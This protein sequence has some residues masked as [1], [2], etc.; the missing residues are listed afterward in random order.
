MYRILYNDS[1]IFDPYGNDNEVVT[2]ASMSVEINA[3]AYMDFAMSRRHPL[4][5]TIAERDGV[6]T[7]YWD[8]D[9]LFQGVIESIDMDINGN[10]AV[11]CVSALDYLNDTVVRP[12]ST[13][14]GEQELTAPSSVDGYFQWLI[15]Q[16]NKHVKDSNKLFYIGVNQGANLQ[17]NN[18]IYRSSTNNP[19]TASEISNQIIDSLGGYLLM[20]YEDGR[21]ILDLYS[22][23]H[24]MNAQIIDFGVNLKDFSKKI[25]TNDQYTALI[26]KGGSPQF[27][28]GGFESGDFSY[29]ESHPDTAIVTDKAQEGSYS[30]Y[31][32]EGVAKYVPASFF[33]AKKNGRYKSTVYVKN[34]RPSN[35][36]IHAGYQ[37]NVLDS[38]SNDSKTVPFTIPNDDQWHECSYEFSTGVENN[39]KIRPYWYSDNMSNSGN[40]RVY[41]DGFGFSRLIGNNTVSE[42]PIDLTLIPNDGTRYDSDIIKSEDV[43]YNPNRVLR[44]GYREKVFTDSTI[45]NVEDLMQAAI[46]ELNKLAEPTIGLDV[47][48]IDLALYMDGYT[49]LN[50]GDAV[51]VRSSIHN[52]D[53]Y[54]MVSSINLNLQDP[55]NSEYVIGQAYDSL[56]G[57]QSGYLRSLSSG[58]NSSLDAVASLDQT[59]KDQAIKIGSVTEA[60]KKAQDTAD[61][62]SSKAD[63]AQQSADNAQQT[64]NANK[65]QISAVKDKQSKQDALIE[66]AKKDIAAS[67]SEISGI[68]DRMT[69]MDSDIDKVQSDIDSTRQEAQKN[70]E[71]FRAETNET[72]QNVR[73]S[74]SKAQSDVDAVAKKA[75]DLSD[76]LDATKATVS[77]TVTEFGEVKTTATNA[78]SK[79]D[80]SLQ[81][82]TQASQTATSASQKATSAYNDAQTAITKSSEAVQTAN[83]VSLSL[84]TDY[85]TKADADA[86]YATQSS[87]TATSD[88]IKTEVSKT[89]ATKATVD[90]LE[91]IANNAIQTWTGKG[92]P[93]LN[94]KPAS[95]WNT[96][97][98][99]TQHSGDI[100][101][102]TDTGYS[103]RFGSSDGSTYSWTLIKD[104]DISKA[105]ADA[106]KAQKT[107]DSATSGVSE[108]KSSIPVTYATKTELTQKADSITSRV[109][110][111][112][113]AGTTTS[114]KV[115]QLEQKTD[116]IKSTVSEQGSKL[117]NAVTTISQ[118]SQKADSISTSLSQTNKNLDALS[119]NMIKNPGFETGDFTNWSYTDSSKVNQLY[120]DSGNQLAGIYKAV[121]WFPS[122]ADFSLSANSITV[123]ANHTYEISCW[124]WNDK[125]VTIRLGFLS[126][127]WDATNMLFPSGTTGWQRI[128]TTWKFKSSLSVRPTIIFNGPISDSFPV[129]LDNF[130]VRDITEGVEAF[131]TAN[132]ALSKASTLEQR[133]DGITST[134]S[135]QAKKL[136]STVTTVSQVSQ[137]A[138]SI[139]STVQQVQGTANSALSK[140]S[141]LEQTLDGFKTTVS[142]TYETK[143]DSLKKQTALEQSINGFK[144]EVSN[145]YETKD[146]AKQSNLVLN[147]RFASDTKDWVVEDGSPQRKTDPVYGTYGEMKIGDNG[148]RFYYNKVNGWKN[149]QTYAYSFLAKASASGSTITPNRGN[150]LSAAG[151]TH[152]ITTE[153]QRF[154][155]T[156]TS[157]MDIGTFSFNP[158]NKS[159]TYYITDV[160][161]VPADSSTIYSTKSYVDQTSRTVSLGVV[162]EYK[163]G[164]H[165]SALATASDITAAKD[166]ITSTVSK[167]YL[168]KKDATNTYLNQG[169]A[170]STYLNKDT[171]ASTYATKTEVK[172]TSDSLTVSIKQSLG[173]ANAA[174]NS[175]LVKNGDFESNSTEGWSFTGFSSPYVN[176][177][178][179]YTGTYKLVAP[180]SGSGS[181]AM[182]ND[183][184]IP[185]YQGQKFRFRC[186]L[187]PDNTINND[188]TIGFIGD[189]N[190]LI[191]SVVGSVTGGGWNTYSAVITVPSGVRSMRARIATNDNSFVNLRVDS[192]TV[193]DVT[194]GANAQ[195]TANTASSNAA[196]AQNRVGNLETCIKMTTDGVRVGKI[197]NGNFSGYSA[198]VNSA[199]SFDVL[200]GSSKTI[201]KFSQYGLDVSVGDSK[202]MFIGMIPGEKTSEYETRPYGYIGSTP[203]FGN[204]SGMDLHSGIMMGFSTGEHLNLVND[205]G[206]IDITAGNRI[207]LLAKKGHVTINGVDVRGAGVVLF[208]K[209]D[210][211]NYASVDIP[212]QYDFSY[213]NYIMCFFKTNDGQ[214]FGG[215]AYHPN[216]KTYNFTTMGG[217]STDMSYIKGTQWAFNGAKATRKTSFQIGPGYSTSVNNNAVHIVAILG[218]DF[219]HETID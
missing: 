156:I 196:N 55:A 114:S 146:E 120:V 107:A 24:T 215:T 20:R 216:G 83:S 3:A 49:H 18:F 36:V 99:K 5:N 178:L 219:Y 162:E 42:D 116:E 109:E 142:Q 217:A 23:V 190:A 67:E 200:N 140:A 15:D 26:A 131:G 62:A 89:Y 128:V 113:Q 78:A 206:S 39:T 137:K 13:I 143:N 205:F 88:Q 177:S 98:L 199:G 8:G 152:T 85:Q 166:S 29:W 191:T 1:I 135:E 33:Y 211:K 153:W 154:S 100:Y 77:Q 149:G 145:T 139:S 170:A 160:S 133:V 134:V 118:V 164:Q 110:E 102:D 188:L 173:I 184:I 169:T 59:T 17:R 48:A 51:R 27:M 40:R 34:E 175:V 183:A 185:V 7:L 112:A 194:D 54:L 12:Y 182:V 189:N 144:T 218:F 105:I 151:Q 203:S 111:V 11:S 91:N 79:A 46:K 30:S 74:V 187:Y 104:T 76:D 90:A 56:T 14:A 87:L 93:T 31:V 101:Y 21:H 6:V 84:K 75:S 82:S 155:G 53:E 214:Y 195:S 174:A 161:L 9:I 60:T 44:Y 124:I 212:S 94:N 16:H 37:T 148:A 86:K 38:W 186:A 28:N 108:L 138:D 171:A 41:F 163:K 122:T 65:E 61:S 43:I 81:V 50:V 179:P 192:I 2:D 96:A 72:V 209:D 132:S 25:D 165:G 63:N 129:R 147:P 150:D 117:N 19:T 213:F 181:H 58:I 208:D 201:A 121:I 168:S 127:R 64:A 71:S 32:I 193:T 210:G 45:T 198:L 4:Y 202:S 207:N 119:S 69:Q 167:D 136:D 73:D 123:V 70:L 97:A 22:D 125:N 157:N 57:Q 180:I 172:Q 158:S 68:N 95:D 176:S 204:H 35:I 10:K 115:T 106:A 66:Q 47:K 126:D 80:Q 141:T 130:E 103:Y 159:L 52:T 92:A 197:S